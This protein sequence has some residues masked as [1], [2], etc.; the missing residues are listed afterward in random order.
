[1]FLTGRWSSVGYIDA[2]AAIVEEGVVLVVVSTWLIFGAWYIDTQGQ[3]MPSRVV[4][5]ASEYSKGAMVRVLGGI[6][7]RGLQGLA[8]LTAVSRL[9]HAWGCTCL[10]CI[11]LG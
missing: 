2:A 5:V 1:V 7:W 3:L 4:Q 9:V 11:Q 8:I 10:D 6:F